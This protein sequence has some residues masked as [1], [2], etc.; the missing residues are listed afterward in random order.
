MKSA[1]KP[2]S[3]EL[4]TKNYAGYIINIMKTMQLKS[5]LNG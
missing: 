1:L 2:E 4:Y 3:T 5:F